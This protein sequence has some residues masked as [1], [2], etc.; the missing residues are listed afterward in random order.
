MKLY[1]QAK[2]IKASKNLC[3]SCTGTSYRYIY[4]DTPS[5]RLLYYKV[6]VVLHRISE[7]L[8]AA[9]SKSARDS[10]LGVIRDLHTPAGLP[11][12]S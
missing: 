5:G 11:Y 9:Q 2:A 12:S 10:S 8:M 1:T 6:H 7:G 4:R 3:T